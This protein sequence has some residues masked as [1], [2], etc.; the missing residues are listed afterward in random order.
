MS[1]V[2]FDSSLSLLLVALHVFLFRRLAWPHFIIHYM[3]PEMMDGRVKT[4]HPRVCS[5]PCLCVL[6]LSL[7][8]FFSQTIQVA[9]SLLAIRT[10]PSHVEAMNSHGIIPTDLLVRGICLC[11][12]LLC[13]LSPFAG[14]QSLPL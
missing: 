2:A 4:L 11:Y 7:H 8:L 12:K 13:E 5:S 6:A 3:Y 1:T 9:G 10:S 14:V